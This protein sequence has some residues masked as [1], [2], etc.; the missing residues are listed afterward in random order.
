MGNGSCGASACVDPTFTIHSTVQDTTQY[1]SL[2]VT[3]VAGGWI[4]A[5]TGGSAT[6]VL[7]IPVA[8]GAGTG[9]TLSYTI[10]ASDA[11]DHQTRSAMVR[12]AVENKAGTEICGLSATS[13]VLDLSAVAAS[14][15]TLTYTIACDTTPANAVDIT[16][17]A[18]SSLTETTLN[19]YGYYIQT[20]TGLPARQ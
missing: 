16:F 3:G 4:K 8:A 2:S 17:Q 15:G 12:I 10:F 13:E 7:R 5:L 11:T 6:A 14:T 1:S 19:F 20:G 9:G 18:V